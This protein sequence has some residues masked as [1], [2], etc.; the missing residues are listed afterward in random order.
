MYRHPIHPAIVHFPIGAWGLGTLVDV[1]VYFNAIPPAYGNN[2][3]ELIGAGLLFALGAMLTGGVD[4]F[5]TLKRNGDYFRPVMRHAGMMM[6]VWGLYLAS[7][8]T[9]L[10]EGVISGPSLLPLILSVGG[11]LGLLIGGYLGGH[12]VYGLGV[13]VQNSPDPLETT[14]KQ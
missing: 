6:I 10:N 2:S 8:L 4:F 3:T 11:F 9:R 5:K 7:L 13:N 12:L 1:L 14:Q